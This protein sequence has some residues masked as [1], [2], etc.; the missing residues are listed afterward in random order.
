MIMGLLGS[1]K[2]LVSGGRVDVSKRFALQREAISGT[3]SRFYMARDLRNGKIVGLKILDMEKTRAVEERYKGLN[4]PSEGAIGMLLKHPRIVETYEHGMTTDGAAYI[5]LE[6]LDGADFNSLIV[7]QDPCLA[8]NRLRFIRQAA[9]AVAAVH[10]AGFIHR[11]ICPRNF[12]LTQKG[13]QDLKLIDFGLTVPATPPF[14]QPG[15]RTGNPNYMAPEIVRR[16]PTDQRVDVF[17]LGATIYEFCT[18]TLPWNR[19]A[20]GLAA[21]THDQPP[22]DIL[23]HRPT[24]NPDLAK[25]IHWCLEADP[26]RR[27]PSVEKFL[28]MLR[29][30]RQETAD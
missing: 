15:V 20:T 16:K 7:G 22:T 2:A 24:L 8:A 28:Q 3:M 25:A 23:Q 26:A 14:L 11:D 19:G 21:M 5:V 12:L 9:E 6:F 30:V 10:A 27:C 4:K 17:A 29:V 13:G 1:L 18:G